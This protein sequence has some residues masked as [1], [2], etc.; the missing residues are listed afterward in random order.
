VTTDRDERLLHALS[1]DVEE[2]FQ[3]ANLRGHFSRESWDRVPSRID[4]GMDAILGALERRGA[5]ATF[6]FLGWI[7]ERHPALVRRCMDGGHE[8]ASHGYEH[9]FLQDLGRERLVDDLA[10]TEDALVAAGAPRPIGFRASTFTLTRSTWWAFDVLVERGYRYDSSV[11]PVRH[12][13]YGVPDFDP[14][15]SLVRTPSNGEIVEFPV[16]TYRL[17]GRNLPV[18]GGGYFRLLPVA[19]TRHA[20]AALEKRG[21][22]GALYLHPWEFDPG[23]P[24][25]PAPALKRARHYLNLERTLP[26]LEHLLARFRFGTMK[27]VLA[28]QGY[29]VGATAQPAGPERS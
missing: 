10:R 12:P 7:A 21:R 15:I 5:H 2:Y 8:I 4:V 11:H 26:R 22:P 1:F 9:A 20:L 13:V 3:V 25:C 14:G 23:Q 28:D 19:V 27:E 18:G 29:D 16:S 17:L 24:R 6:F